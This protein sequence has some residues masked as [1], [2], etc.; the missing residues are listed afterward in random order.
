MMILISTSA[1]R[2]VILSL[3]FKKLCVAIPFGQTAA[4]CGLLGD[5]SSA[6]CCVFCGR[7]VFFFEV[8][9]GGACRLV[10]F[11]VHF[12]KVLAAIARRLLQKHCQN[13]FEKHVTLCRYVKDNFQLEWLRSHR[14]CISRELSPAAI[15]AFC[16][17]SEQM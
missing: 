9:F 11:R 13:L 5:V 14:I 12:L 10:I 6:K 2:I 3:V 7:Q 17:H 4:V 1:C 15:G 16:R 8:V